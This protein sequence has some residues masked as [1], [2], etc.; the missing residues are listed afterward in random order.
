MRILFVVPY[1]PS[2]IRPRPYHLIRQLVARGNE[3]TV[4]T[5]VADE[6]EKAAAAKLAQECHRVI[7]VSLPRWR[8]L[9]NCCR[10]LPAGDP[11]QSA[12]AWQPAL[13]DKLNVLLNPAPGN[14]QRPF[15][16]VHIEHLRGARYGLH[17]LKRL[18]GQNNRLPVVWDSVD[19]ITSLFEQATTQ[20]KSQLGRLMTRF[21]APRTGRYEGWLLSQFDRTLVAA[22]RDRQALLALADDN[23]SSSAPIQVL[24]NG[25]DLDYFH[26][27]PPTER[28]PTSIVISGK[29]SY[30]ANV[31]MTLYFANEILPLIW[32]QRPDARLTIVGK[33]PPRAIQA[34]AHDRRVTVTGTVAEMRPFLQH[35]TLAVAPLTYGA[36]IQ[37]KVLEAM[38]CATPVVAT[39]QAVAALN[40]ESGRNMLLAADPPTFANA[41][42]T[43][44]DD[45]AQRKT[46][47][48][49]GRTYVEQHHSWAT[50]AGRLETIYQEAIEQV[51][52][53]LTPL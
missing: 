12:Y 33:N 10:A 9:W 15:D 8:T 46:I 40:A 17:I 31:T 35:A 19:C 53:K 21:E 11:L 52:Q 32:Q 43:L 23:S 20:S 13:A 14:G 51:H 26:P 18:N 28:L 27:Q 22:E 30:H 6:T 25:V 2:L 29:M 3:V 38:S 1:T 42:V 48:D 41:V 16:V 4:L 5:L 45:P 49:G 36:G 37:N 44:L 7:T 24:P 39:A 47:G 50:I 34:L